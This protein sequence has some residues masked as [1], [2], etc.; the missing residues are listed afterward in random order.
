MT[1]L[2]KTIAPLLSVT[3]IFVG[4][5]PTVSQARIVRLEIT[6]TKPAFDGR[7]FGEVGAYERV[8]GKA[9]GEV[10]P[11]APSNAVIQ[12]I[13]LAPKNAKGMVEYST[14]IDI[15]RPVDRTRAN[16]VLFFN[17][18]NRGN[19]GG[20]TLINTDIPGG[21]A[22]IGNTNALTEAGDGFMQ[23]QGYTM[24]WFGWQPDVVAGNN[25]MM[26]QV[27]VASNPDGSSITG[28]VRN[29]LNTSAPTTTLALQSGWF[30]PA[31]KP[32]P[33]VSTD[34]KTALADG[35][36]PTLSVRVRE[37]EPRMVI[38]NTEWSFGSC[39]DGRPAAASDT[40]LC[41]QAGFKPGY[42]YELVYRAKD[43]LV[44]GLGF[45]AARDLGAFLKTQAKDDGG[46]ANPAYVA[47][48]KA[49]VMGS[50]QSGRFIR[51]LIHLGF[52]RDEQG[53]TVFE[54]ALPHIGGGLMPL[55]IRFGQPG[56]A[57]TNAIDHLFPG[58]EFPFAYT[59]VT[60]PLTGRTQG[61]LDRCLA[62]SSCPKIVHA[63][64]ALELWELRQ[65]LGFTDPL[66]L[67][68]LDEPANVRS[69]IMASTQHAQAQL[70]LPAKEPFLAC[71]Q[72]PNPNPHNWTMRALLTHL[73]A[74]V[75][76]GT[77]PPPSSRPTIAA[78]NL[79]A[80]D[81][82]HF[83]R[84]PAN[85]YGGVTRPAV[86]FAADNDPL[87]VQ[88]HG[89]AYNAADA[90]GILSGDP[91]KLSTGRYGNLVAQVDADGNDLGGI[92]DVFV[93]VPIG[94]YTGWNLFDKNFFEDGFCTL[95]GSFIPF[96][97]T[98]QERLAIGDLR[99]SIEERY[100]TKVAYVA[101]FKK[102][103]NDLVAQRFL[104]ADDATRLIL[105]AERDGIRSAP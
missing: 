88:D 102:A 62:T 61:I 38:P 28:V 51:T 95:S 65:S 103:A 12:D 104:L 96:A 71:Q 82:V 60:D 39:A 76:D 11:Q 64:T 17:I 79:V 5:A 44:L 47:G 89:S 32:Y 24:V 97:P 22:N 84:I 26:M 42:L 73:T 101:A 54:G 4:L 67:K 1:S 46:V 50:S 80:P 49:I 74:W 6:E 77:E 52:N 41:Y 85:F 9:Y 78:G 72:Q 55:N 75:K 13:A 87:H 63:A 31:S 3:V 105:E 70:P 94:T 86:K 100:P 91:P 93:A 30:T 48:A 68:D 34:N 53:N 18:I 23:Q 58:A 27:P 66:G 57:T 45:A 25:R 35:F 81:Q 19:K 92:R 20:L 56:R 29:E 8:I 99:P 2:K 14:D 98:R 37:N 7:N 16:G 10:D 59:S 43:P 15:L 36:L 83:P 90:S 69:Y 21:P 33:T 40:Q